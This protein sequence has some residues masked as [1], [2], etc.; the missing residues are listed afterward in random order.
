MTATV[1]P[2]T[3]SP[4]DPGTLLSDFFQAADAEQLR[5]SVP[6][7]ECRFLHRLVDGLRSRHTL[8]LGCGHGVSSVAIC[9]GRQPDPDARHLIIDPD[10][11]DRF[12]GAGIARLQR[13]GIDNFELIEQSAEFALPELLRAGRQVDFA[14]VDARLAPAKLPIDLFYIGRLLRTDGVVAIYVD[15]MRE[16]RGALREMALDPS[17]RLIGWS[18]RMPAE[19]EVGRWMKEALGRALRPLSRLVFDDADNDAEARLDPETRQVLR[20]ANTVAFRKI[21]TTVLG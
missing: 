19:P 7:A 3:L 18:G 21:A 15:G 17:Y 5:G 1:P 14:F 12:G 13:T 9:S 4:I 20:T 11:T 6:Q 16:V 10:Q 2:P 8:E